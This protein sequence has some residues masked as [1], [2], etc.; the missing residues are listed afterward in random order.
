MKLAFS[1]QNL[2]KKISN[3]KFYDSL[4]SANVVAPCGKTDRKD[5][6]NNRFSHFANSPLN[7]IQV[8]FFS[9][10]TLFPDIREKIAVLEGFQP[11]PVFFSSD[12]II[13]QM[14][15]SADQCQNGIG[16]S[17]VKFSDKP[18]YPKYHIH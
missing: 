10:C 14:K 13:G 2:R 3:I 6:A 12:K 8:P 18:L 16:G 11:L 1:Q 17:K 9:F 15:M 4:S 5:E 7:D